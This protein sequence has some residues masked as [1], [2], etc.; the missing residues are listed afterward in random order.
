MRSLNG[1]RRVGD[2]DNPWETSVDEV[3]SEGPDL[4]SLLEGQHP[5]DKDAEK[6]G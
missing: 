4:N 2:E 6:R 1:Q 3:E 5:T